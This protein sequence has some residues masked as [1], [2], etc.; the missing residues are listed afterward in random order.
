M[1]TLH[2]LI[3]LQ[4]H[5]LYTITYD[6]A[7]WPGMYSSLEARGLGLQENRYRYRYVIAI[8]TNG[9]AMNI[10]GSLGPA[11]KEIN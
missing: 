8:D 11:P 3:S 9:H 7:T 5:G 1:V 4:G 2:A 6:M 10:V